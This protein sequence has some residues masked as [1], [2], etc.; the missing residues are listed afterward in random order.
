MSPAPSCGC[1]NATPV[2]REGRQALVVALEDGLRLFD[3]PDGALRRIPGAP[4]APLE[5]LAYDPGGDRLWAARRDTLFVTALATGRTDTIAGGDGLPRG[6]HAFL[7]VATL[8]DGRRVA[9]V[10]VPGGIAVADAAAA[11]PRFVVHDTTSLPVLPPAPLSS[12]VI[13]P[14]GRVVITSSGGIGVVALGADLLARPQPIA[15]YGSEDGLLETKIERATPTA[16]PGVVWLAT[17]AGLARLHVPDR[18]DRPARPPALAITVRSATDTVP[19][20]NGATLPWRAASLTATALVDE[21]DRGARLRF[22]FRLRGP[23]S[24]DTATVWSAL[25][26]RRF[27]GLADGDYVL[28]VRGRDALGTETQPRT[29]RFTVLPPPW[30]APST[31]VL[32][33]LGIAATAAGAATLRT[34]RL[35]ERTQQ[36]ERAAARIR[37]S[38]ERFR[39]VFD[40]GIDAQLLVEHG[41]VVGA[42]PAA[43]TLFGEP[44]IDLLLGRSIDA[45]LETQPDATDDAGAD[46]T[47]DAEAGT[48]RAVDGTRIPVTLRRTAIPLDTGTVIHVELRDRREAERLAAER[49]ELEQQLR[50]SQRL[51]SL[52]TLAGGVAHDFNNLLTVIRMNAE[53]AELAVVDGDADGA[54]DGLT[55]VLGASDRAR[56]IVRQILTFSRRAP[57]T[58]LPLHLGT[59]VSAARTLLRSTLPTAV[60]LELDDTTGDDGWIAGEATQLQQLLLNLASNA[61]HAMR[62]TG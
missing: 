15:T 49:E 22:A 52:G 34:R 29:L 46:A 21:F 5:R 6:P 53:L 35:R 14:D 25:R 57:A 55:A 27:E 42:N 23:T 32:Y 31:L 44:R 50:A 4:G 37:A 19:L 38:E 16:T 61:E 51:E 8:A 7:R 45:L 18:A 47:A 41:H 62:R 10:G 59:L 30:R 13:L 11:R 9:I 56:D 24:T 43:L 36:A 2:A 1:G 40:R 12:A 3:W 28:E 54:R 48:V 39:L 20:A 26:E 60:Q 33:G 58:R 17:S